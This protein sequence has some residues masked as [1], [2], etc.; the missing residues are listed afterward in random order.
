MTSLK[1]TI[2]GFLIIFIGCDSKKSE[3]TQLRFGQFMLTEDRVTISLISENTQKTESLQYA[4]LTSFKT[5]EPGTYQVEVNAGSNTVLKKKFSFGPRGKFTLFVYGKVE[6]TSQL[7]DQTTNEQLH[8]IVSGAEASTANGFLPQLDVI[9]EHVQ[10][11]SDKAQLRWFN[12]VPFENTLTA[13]A[14]RA[15]GV[16]LGSADYGKPAKAQS[17]NSG[18]YSL[19]WASGS[20]TRATLEQHLKAKTLYTFFVLPDLNDSTKLHIL[21]GASSTK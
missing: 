10:G 14:S 4:E 6:D 12:L 16:S 19:S 21:T 20:V 13:R 11:G 17:L 7:N 9:D 2:L 18:S 8:R 3:K 5:I 1:I 15:E